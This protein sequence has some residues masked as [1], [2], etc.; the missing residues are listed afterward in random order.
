VQPTASE[1]SGSPASLVSWESL[2]LQGRNFVGTGPTPDE[3]TAFSGRPAQEPVRAYVGLKSADDVQARAQLAA[4][5]LQ[6]AGGFDRSVLVVVTTTGTGWAAAPPPPGWPASDTARLRALTGC[7]TVGRGHPGGRPFRAGPQNDNEHRH[8]I[9]ADP[10]EGSPDCLPVYRDRRNVRCA[11]EASDLAAPSGPWP[12][13]RL[14]YLQNASD[15]IVWWS[16]DLL[17]HQPDWLREPPGR[18]VLPAMRWLPWVTFWQVTAD[19]VFSTGV[20]DG[21]GHVYLDAYVDAWAAVLQPPDWTAADTSNL[22]A[23]IG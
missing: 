2:G 1:R 13:P 14:V 5:Q 7:A 19:M 17:L 6:R 4:R 8:G 23:A 20:P 9:V 11:D 21:H 15:P 10:E 12:T 18:D 3:L 22:Y 16:G